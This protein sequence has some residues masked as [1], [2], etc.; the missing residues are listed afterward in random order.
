MEIK[1]ISTL[2]IGINKDTG[3]SVFPSDKLYDAFNIKFLAQ[4]DNSNFIIQMN[5]VIYYVS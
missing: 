5:G 3:N 2:P 1:N 4:K